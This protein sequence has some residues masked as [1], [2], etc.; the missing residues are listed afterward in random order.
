MYNVANANSTVKTTRMFLFCMIAKVQLKFNFRCANIR[1]SKALCAKG[2]GGLGEAYLRVMEKVAVQ[3]HFWAGLVMGFGM[4]FLPYASLQAQTVADVQLAVLQ[5]GVEVIG[6]PTRRR[7]PIWCGTAT[8]R[9]GWTCR[10]MCPT[11]T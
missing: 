5:Y 10:R 3:A 6:I 9:W 2:L 1:K 4:V 8:R 7:S 11:W